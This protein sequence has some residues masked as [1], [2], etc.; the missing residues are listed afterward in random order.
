MEEYSKLPKLAMV[1]LSPAGLRKTRASF[2]KGWAEG[3]KSY[4]FNISRPEGHS[5]MDKALAC[6]TSGQG[7]NT[8]TTKDFFNSQKIIIAPNLS[9]TLTERTLSLQMVWS[10][11]G[12]M[13]IVMGEVKERNC[14]KNPSSPISEANTDII[15]MHGRKVRKNLA[16]VSTT[17]A[18]QMQAQ[19]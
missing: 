7:L 1:V 10:N 6:H 3:E 11:P 13:W 18:K 16:W 4:F 2:S 5:A 12:N 17:G 9:D 8:D 14:G 19:K 15:A